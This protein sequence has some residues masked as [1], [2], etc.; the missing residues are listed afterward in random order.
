MLPDTPFP[1]IFM[2][3]VAFMS[4][5]NFFSRHYRSPLIKTLLV[6]SKGRITIPKS[7][8]QHMGVRQGC[9]MA[10]SLTGDRIE[11]RV[12]NPSAEPADGFGMLLSNKRAVP[13]D[14][15]ATMIGLPVKKCSGWNLKL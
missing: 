12:F 11:M 3:Y 1:R 13:A 15:N 5:S 4:P 10:F 2:S 6:T 8:R 9:R 7:V 14:F